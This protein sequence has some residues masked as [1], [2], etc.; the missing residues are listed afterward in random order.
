[1]K[2]IP[3]EL[4]LLQVEDRKMDT[5]PIQRI[6]IE[7]QKGNKIVGDRQLPRGAKKLKRL[8]EVQV[9]Q[10]DKVENMLFILTKQAYSVSH[11]AVS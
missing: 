2:G 10:K 9:H 4:I 8:P 7:H 6:M 11:V 5:G 1:M 3:F